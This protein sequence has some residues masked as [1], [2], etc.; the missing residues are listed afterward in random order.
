MS[1][2]NGSKAKFNIPAAKN[3][4]SL[5]LKRKWVLRELSRISARVHEQTDQKLVFHNSD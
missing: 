4:W 2:A 3:L 5:A 1:K